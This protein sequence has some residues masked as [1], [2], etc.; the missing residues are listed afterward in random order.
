MAWNSTSYEPRNTVLLGIA[1]ILGAAFLLSFSDA[2]IKALGAQF[3]LWQIIL[4]RSA[5]AAVV[6]GAGVR[7]YFGQGQLRVENGRW[8][9]ARSLCLTAMW[10][11]YYCALPSMSLALAAACYY[12]TPV[13]MALI[14]RVVWG[15]RISP[16]GWGAIALT[17]LGVI[18]IVNPAPGQMTFHVLLPLAAAVFYALAG[19]VTHR[20]CQ[21]ETATAM[22]F[23]L[24]LCLCAVAGVMLA[25][26]ALTGIGDNGSFVLSVWPALT[27]KDWMIAAILGAVLAVVSVAVAFAYRQAPTQIVGVCDTSYMGFAAIWGVTMFH[28]PLEMQQLVGLLLIGLGAVLIGYRPKPRQFPPHFAT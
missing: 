25:G 17:L 2:L 5:V 1:A 3:G 26:L 11:C 4:I 28:E 10:M 14:S 9:W 23:N 19:I 8:V 6:L 20:R 15:E 21:N 24:N 16:Q 22:A 13:W 12:T 27:P 7:I 18:A